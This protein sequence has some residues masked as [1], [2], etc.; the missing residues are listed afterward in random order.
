MNLK[1]VVRKCVLNELSKYDN[2]ESVQHA[3]HKEVNID[4]NELLVV[5]GQTGSG[6]T[7]NVNNELVALSMIPNQFTH[8]TYVSNNPNDMT[9]TKLKSLIRI[10]MTRVSYQESEKFITEYREYIK[11]YDEI[12]KKN[13]QYKL[14]PE[15][16][17]DILSHLGL[18][19]FVDYPIYNIVIYDD[20]MNVFKKPQSKEFKMLFDY[21]H[22]RTTYIL[23]LQSMK[24]L[25]TEI[26]A[27]MGGLWLFGNFNRQ[28][29]CY[30]Y[31]QMNV[32]MDKEEL[33]NIYRQLSKNSY[34]FIRYAPSGTEMYI[35]N[36][37]GDKTRIDTD[38]ESDYDEEFYED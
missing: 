38:E 21:R 18:E 11:A 4:Y 20:A 7:F 14:T 29:F 33:W 17:E 31:S 24:G 12:I 3:I 22:Y 19:D 32:P 10:P 35:V 1:R 2:D 28:Q 23:M 16:R 8:I 27:Q 15:C 30:M 26:K 9:I 6:K 37:N 13:W 36:S 25:V 5:V 34:L